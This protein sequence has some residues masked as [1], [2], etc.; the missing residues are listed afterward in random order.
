MSRVE[1]CTG[2]L[3]FMLP[4]TRIATQATCLRLESNSMAPIMLPSDV[5]TELSLRSASLWLLEER[6]NSEK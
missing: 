1:R 3:E 2:G 5:W 4:T 6:S